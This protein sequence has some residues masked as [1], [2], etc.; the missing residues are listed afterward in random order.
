MASK[1]IFLKSSI[2]L[3]NK[4][5][6]PLGYYIMIYG[7][8]D[9]LHENIDGIKIFLGKKKIRKGLNLNVGGGQHIIEGF[10]QLDYYSKLY[11][12]DKNE[13]L[14]TR[15]E[16]DMR[17][18]DIPYE[19]DTVDN[20]YC[21]QVIEHVETEY[22]E[23]FFYESFRV[24]KK[25]GVLRILCPDPAF[26][27]NVLSF[28]NDWMSWKTDPKK[29][30][31]YDEISQENSWRF[32]VD[33]MMKQK[34]NLPNYGLSK[35]IDQFSYESL[36]E[37]LRKDPIFDDTDL[38][39][40]INNWDFKR[41]SQLSKKVGFSK[42]IESKSGSSVSSEMQGE[43]VDTFHKEISLHVDIVK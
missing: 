21:C 42:T 3:I 18:Q 10:K 6:S 17:S 35:P 28:K 34:L 38:G 26:L 20:I 13:F 7:Y 37:E 30:N 15:V 14:K 27:Y 36:V 9:M 23:K 19:N 5:L 22:V 1:N 24:L 33:E 40:H 16:Y 8:R 12:P 32:F 31:G 2:K 41:I 29:N 43:D 25:G 39:R 11:Y 4:V